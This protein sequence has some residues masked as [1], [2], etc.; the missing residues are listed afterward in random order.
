[1]SALLLNGKEI[2]AKYTERY[3]KEIEALKAA[4]AS[5]SLA[6]VRV[7]ESQDAVLY[8]RAIERVT[9]K[10]GVRYEALVYPESVSESEL[11]MEI[12]KLNDAPAIT[13]IMVF[14]PLPKQFQLE[15]ILNAVDIWKEVEGRRLML[16]GAD[17]ISTPT[18]TACAVLADE[19]GADLSGK[20][21][22]V[23]GRSDVVGKPASLLLLDRNLTV[24][25]CHSKTKDL[26]AHLRRAD[27]VI[28]TVGKPKFLRGD[29][30]KPGAI[31][32]DV[33]EN[34]VDGKLVGDVDFDSVKEK[35]AFLSPVPGGVGPV[36]NLMLIRNLILL[37]KMRKATHGSR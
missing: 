24:T 12:K 7:G 6:T 36:T 27:V 5:L 3:T 1:M 37:H 4:G 28:A 19:S 26:E 33:G 10:V 18:A 9:Q 8:S 30:V 34:F 20:E 25:V 29:W 14:A 23:I 15:K 13:G 22:V 2:A 31:V 16:G 32:I 21:A 17:K 35:A 11:L